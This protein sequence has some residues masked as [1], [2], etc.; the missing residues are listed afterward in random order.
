MELKYDDVVELDSRV[1][2]VGTALLPISAELRGPL[3]RLRA[4]LSDALPSHL[5]PELYLPVTKFPLQI[6]GEVNWDMLR[7]SLESLAENEVSNFALADS[8]K[9]PLVTETEKRLQSLWAAVLGVEQDRVGTHDFPDWRGDLSLAIPPVSMAND[10]GNGISLSTS[11]VF[12]NTRLADTARTA[13]ERKNDPVQRSED[14]DEVQR[15]ELWR[16]VKGSADGA[17]TQINLAGE[18]SHV[19]ALCRVPVGDIEDVYPCTPLQEGLMSATAQQPHAYVG[20][21]AYRVLD[22]VDLARFKQSWGELVRVAPIARTRIV[23]G[24]ISGALQVVVRQPLTWLSGSNVDQYLEDDSG[25]GM[26]YGSPLMRLAIVESPQKGCIFVFTAHHS[27]YDGWSLLKMFEAVSRIYSLQEG[28]R[29]PPY[30]HFI[31]YIEERRRDS[32]SA[33]SFWRSQLDGDA[34]VPFPAPPTPPYQPSPSQS[35]SCGIHVGHLTGSITL[36][37]FLRAAWALTV[38]SRSGDDVLFAMPLSGRSAPVRG[39]ADM[40]APTIATVP[41]RIRIDR[42]QPVYDYLVAVH[43]QAVDMLPFEHTGLQHIR[44]LVGAGFDMRHIFAVQPI[45]KSHELIYRDILG[46]EMVRFPINEFYDYALTVECE[47]GQDLTAVQVVCQFDENVVSGRQMRRL[48]GVFQNVIT[49]LALFSSG[50]GN[51]SVK[52]VGDVEMVSPQ[53]VTQMAQWDREMPEKE[54]ALVHELVRR[55]ALSKHDAPAVSAWDGSL[56]H[57]ELDRHS[58]RLANRLVALGIGPEAMVPLCLD[59]SKWVV[60]CIFAILKAGGAVVPV[61]ADPISRL[62]AILSNTGAQVVLASPCYAAQLKDLAH[63]VLPVDDDFFSDLPS[64]LKRP[65][66]NV[67]PDNVAFVMHT[68]GST[69]TPKGVVLEHGAIATSV[70]VQGEKLG[71]NRDT[72]SL[73]F[74]NLTF[75]MALHDI[76]VPLQFGGCVCLPSEEDK[77]NDLAGAIRRLGANYLLV[78]PTVL[79]TLKPSDCPGLRTIVAGG[80]AVH[81]EHVKPWLAQARVFSAY[82][83]TECSIISTV[84]EYS[85]GPTL[86][87][88]HA[89]AGGAWV[90]NRADHNKLVG[91]GAVGELLVEGPQL[92]RGYLHD[93]D[94]T[95]ASFLY[96]PSWLDRYRLLKSRSE[97]R[98]MYRTGDLVTQNDDGSFNYI[99]R[100]DSQVKIRG[101][102][103]EIGEVEHHVL[104]HATVA[105][106][107]VLYP[108]RGPCQ[109]RLLGLLTLRGLMTSRGE[110]DAEVQPTTPAQVSSALKKASLVREQLLT[111]VPE[112]MVPTVW[113]SLASM[114]LTAS[115]KVDRKKLVQWIEDMDAERFDGLTGLDREGDEGP[116]APANEVQRQLQAV[117]A[118]ILHLSLDQVSLGRS[119]LSMGGDS[120]TGMQLVSRCRTR[121]DMSLL[122][123]DVLQS[124]S[125]AQLALRATASGEAT[126][127]T[128]TASAPFDL[129]PI[130]Q[131][132]M[133]SM[134]AAQGSHD[135]GQERFNQSVC[136]EAGRPIGSQE[137]RR[138]AE[139]LVSRHPMLRARFSQTEHGW[140]QH[141][142]SQVDGSFRLGFHGVERSKDAERVIWSAQRRLDLDKGPVFSL[143]SIRV[144]EDGKQLLFIVAHHLVVDIV[145]WQIMMRELADAVLH[146]SVAVLKEPVSFQRWTRM[147]AGHTLEVGSPAQALPIETPVTDGSSYWGVA[148]ESN[149]YG[150]RV[151]EG[152]VVEDVASLLLGQSPLRTEPV[153]VLL[154]ALFHSFHRVFPDRP[155]PT[156]FNEGHGREPWGNS[157]DL[158]DTVGWFTTMTPIHVS[159]DDDSN[160]IVDILRRVKDTRRSIPER[161]MAYF[162][163]RFLTL[164]GREAFSSHER[165]EVMFN[166]SGRHQ[167][168]QDAE[169]LLQVVPCPTEASLSNV[170]S[171]VRR[172]ALLEID[173]G[174]W[175]NQLSVI[176]GFHQ[177]MQRQPEVRRWVQAYRCSLE[178]LAARLEALPLTFTLADFPLLT[179]TYSELARLQH[180]LLPQNGIANASDVEDIYPCSPI[181]QGIIMGQW[182]DQSRYQ[183]QSICEF[184]AAGARAVDPVKFSRAWQTAVRRHSILRTVLIESVS[185]GHLFYQVVLKSWEPRVVCIHCESSDDVASA[186]AR[187]GRPEYAPG[188][189]WHQLMLCTTAAGQLFARV[190]CHHALMDASSL[191]L[192]FRELAQAYEGVLVDSPAPSYGTYVALLQKSSAAE[193]LEY[194]TSRL[195][196]ARPCFLTPLV[197]ESTGH[198]SLRT[199]KTVVDDMR[200]LHRFR[201][202][203]G[204]TVANMVQLAWALVVSRYTASDDVAFGYVASG[205]DVPIAG[206]NE[207][208]GPLIN[209]T[210]SRIRFSVGRSTVVQAAQQ[211][212]EDFL[213]AYHNQR[214]SLGEILHAL[215][216]SRQG[217]FN[218]VVSYTRRPFE[219]PPTPDGIMAHPL[220]AEDPTEF[221]ANLHVVCGESTMT[222]SLQYSTSLLDDESA[223]RLQDSFRHALFSIA[224]N[225]NVRINQLNIMG[226][227]DTAQLS[228]SATNVTS[229]PQDTVQL[230]GSAD[231]EASSSAPLTHA[232]RLLQELW[233][234]VLNSS[235]MFRPRD[236][237]FKSGGDSIAAMRLVSKAHESNSLWLT[238]ADIFRHPVLGD[239]A[240]AADCNRRKDC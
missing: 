116:R 139:A 151:N 206:V 9:S 109:G 96:N 4:S 165:I 172:L 69:G 231:E 99:G 198:A 28:P 223:G 202:E 12:R 160:D 67:R 144:A 174:T 24:R 209:M 192:I 234:Q 147:L 1:N 50:T 79:G 207:M 164:D 155:V 40:I 141:I 17:Q 183:V 126:P 74:A 19:A 53:E 197:T 190:S 205:R 73:Q 225:S 80:E 5:V 6:S 42:T 61:R 14:V 26:S 210:V 111:R 128:D 200:P 140:K 240:A 70:Q 98:R 34:G 112:Y 213:D 16:E 232:E 59:K 136:L 222:L 36:A 60:V 11:E 8:K 43:Q 132:Y 171:S 148:P 237:F 66:Q 77:M 87:L 178:E 54:P 106:A 91:V 217:L 30:S 182:K 152:L 85:G 64:G 201:G 32:T 230:H 101:Q 58:E 122:L 162:A 161:G 82:G 212:Q 63:H 135:D 25:Q 149:V 107:I 39:V 187:E 196:D 114:P 184:R 179:L 56:S 110:R 157:M 130:Q 15:F 143:D 219:D 173:A 75:D 20:R 218:T 220:S 41:V 118:E 23:P 193:S 105:D 224:T 180:E 2:A 94:K 93:P 163:A 103:I 216:L 100:G 221:E 186:F 7:Q 22:T 10:S 191:H 113:I 129:S 18:L 142:E 84:A 211:V 83:L 57:G 124:A 72:R 236:D 204:V 137:L 156:I 121:H 154:A 115:H 117:V 49:Q 27:V 104:R 95:A 92:A 146:P 127:F 90:V 44:R 62:R 235:R 131:L 199:L 138:A 78:T 150:R 185:E 177:H 228:L 48:L 170:G 3:L 46:L 215:R 45:G 119:F 145:S 47:I 175:G 102:R 89:I 208:A 31:R 120:I 35:M 123:R 81:A 65:Q 125:I 33:E 159:V 188:E 153:E 108:R 238:V 229:A 226:P 169:G 158:S 97:V 233:A 194:W 29:A 133:Q 227:C 13:E 76:L 55:H 86:N 21:W 51:E 203:H 38:S 176:F 166:F 68:S 195:A 189:P 167:Q 168:A 134:A 214:V 88:G 71:I 52:V 239:L 181:Q 37:S